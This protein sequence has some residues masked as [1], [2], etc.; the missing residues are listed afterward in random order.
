MTINFKKL[1]SYRFTKTIVAV[2]LIISSVLIFYFC[3]GTVL[4]IGKPDFYN[5]TVNYDSSNTEIV[6][7]ISD[8]AVDEKM[9]VYRIK[10]SRF[11]N[12]EV[13]NL[14]SAFG[15][16]EPAKEVSGAVT[17]YREGDKE[18]KISKSGYLYTVKNSDESFLLSEETV[19]AEAEKFLNDKGLLPDDFELAGYSKTEHSGANTTSVSEIG[20]T[21]A[22]TVDSHR[23]VGGKA[24]ITVSFNKGGFSAVEQKNN[25]EYRKKGTV[26][27]DIFENFKGKI[28]SDEAD[29]THGE[30]DDFKLKRIEITE[31]EIVYYKGAGF[32]GQKYLQPCIRFSGT[33][34]DDNGNSTTFSS[35]IPMKK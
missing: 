10:S 16:E 3:G 30:K 34:F 2:L 32:I 11:G 18:L 5:N 23:T 35:T 33:A 26:K 6:F 8:E 13:K 31:C 7:K 22:K 25:E 17:Y 28:L 21:F 29:I 9:P 24:A 20:V 14:L 1:F 4:M 27:C 12:F 15:F 19:K